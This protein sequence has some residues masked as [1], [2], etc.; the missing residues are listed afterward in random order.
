MDFLHEKILDN[1]IQNLLIVAGIILLVGLFKKLLSHYTASLSYV[2]INRDWK[3][4]DIKQFSV[5]FLKPLSWF[6]I[7]TITIFS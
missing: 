4:I 2:L 1:S 3:T 6:I 5:M 7:V